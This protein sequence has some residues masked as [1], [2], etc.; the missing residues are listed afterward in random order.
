M[1]VERTCEQCG[2]SYSVPPARAEKTRFCS[3]ACA[4]LG[5]TGERR[6]E[7]CRGCGVT[8]S[9]KLDHGRWQKYCTRPCM[10]ASQHSPIERDCA[11]CGTTFKARYKRGAYIKYCSMQCGADARSNAVIVQCGHC[12]AET[13]KT[14]AQ[15]RR[16]TSGKVF[17]SQECVYKQ[18]SGNRSH[19]YKGGSWVGVSGHRYIYLGNNQWKAEH[20]IV[21][22]DVLKRDLQYCGEP[23]LHLNGDGLDNRKENLYVCMDM[24]EMGEILNGTLPFPTRSNIDDLVGDPL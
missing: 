10:E 4:D 20:R 5:Q 13:R 3:R 22:Q 12:G 18:Y 17:C 1:P 16:S 2:T 14:Q 23:V 8:F 24:S 11:S 15:L 6:E 21:S 7:V 19:F 9:S